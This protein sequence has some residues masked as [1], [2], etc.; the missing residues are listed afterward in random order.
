MEQVNK[1]TKGS[2]LAQIHVENGIKVEL[3]ADILYVMYC[4]DSPGGI[5]E[6]AVGVLSDAD[7]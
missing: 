7:Q 5:T 4:C 2:L 1:K 3:K 6:A